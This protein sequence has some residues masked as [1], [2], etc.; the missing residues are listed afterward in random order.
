MKIFGFLSI[1]LFISSLIFGQT[2]NPS[3]E[4]ILICGVGKNV[5]KAVENTIK[6]IEALGDNFADYAVIIYENNSADNT[7]EQFRTWAQKNNH[8]VFFSQ[9]LL[10]E[11]SSY[12]EENIAIAR[13]IVLSLA[14]DPKYSDFR[15]LI[16]V[17]LDFLT[18]WPIREI[19]ETIRSPIEWDCVSANGIINRSYYYDRYAFRNEEF[20]FGPELLGEW[21]WSNLSKTQF[22]L[23]QDNWMPVYSAFGGLAIYKTASI[24]PFSYSG[25]ITEDLGNFYKQILLSLPKN[26]L[27]LRK[28]LRN[29][30]KSQR[31]QSKAPIILNSPCCEHVSLHA[32]MALHG[33]GKFYINPKMCM[34]YQ[35]P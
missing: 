14:R 31:N 24:L 34:Y 29:T 23:T 17:D 15:Y 27:H 16:M 18:P 26:N 32:S 30:N 5:G 25:T 11:Y 9:T 7:A 35:I 12:R 8:V 33:F 13:N 28:H 21:F 3:Q 4:K 22:N 6:N 10:Q 20:P 2:N 19:L 1:F